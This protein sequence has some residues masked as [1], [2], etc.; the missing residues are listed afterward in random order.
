MAQP[1]QIE[2]E[3]V[4]DA[5][6]IDAEYEI[7]DQIDILEAEAGEKGINYTVRIY[8]TPEGKG[9]RKFLFICTTSNFSMEYIRD[10][11]GTGMYDIW[12][13]KDNHIHKR[14]TKEIEAPANWTPPPAAEEK[15]AEVPDNSHVI[16]SGLTTL[17]EMIVRMNENM[18]ERITAAQA[19]VVPP[20]PRREPDRNAKCNVG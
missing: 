11:Y 13:F 19:A 15:K 17:G 14:W 5:E 9:A 12:V 1:K 4:F 18:N 3:K 16:V 7:D 6:V 8:R 20:P 2:H 10:H